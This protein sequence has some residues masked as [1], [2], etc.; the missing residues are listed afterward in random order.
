MAKRKGYKSEAFAAVHE[1]ATDLHDIGAITLATMREFNAL[2][3]T[4]IVVPS[5]EVKPLP[6]VALQRRH[7]LD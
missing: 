6:R 2:C 3:L 7:D 4:Q 5:P 1:T